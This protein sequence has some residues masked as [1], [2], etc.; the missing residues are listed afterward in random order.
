MSI[1]IKQATQRNATQRNATQRNATQRN[2]LT[3]LSFYPHFQVSRFSSCFPD[4]FHFHRNQFLIYIYV[5]LWFLHEV[6]RS[7]RKKY[8]VHLNHQL[9]N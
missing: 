5:P 4:I 9:E 3:R 6:R 7:S 1:P 2:Q 8:L